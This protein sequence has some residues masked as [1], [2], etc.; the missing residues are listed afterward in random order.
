LTHI[1][2]CSPEIDRRN[3]SSSNSKSINS[4]SSD[5]SY[6]NYESGNKLNDNYNSSNC[7]VAT[8]AFGTKWAD[9][10]DIL[11]NWRDNSLKYHKFG[12]L[13]IK[14]YYQIGPSLA[15]FVE[16]SSLFKK[17]TRKI[18]YFIVKKIK[19]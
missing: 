9:E 10:I 16:K 3:S 12:R 8:A 5:Q 1:L 6:N 19:N 4:D 14:F 13:F 11:R 2:N 18:I 7:F 17:I 15:N